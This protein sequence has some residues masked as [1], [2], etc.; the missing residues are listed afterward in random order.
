VERASARHAGNRA[1]IHRGGRILALLTLAALTAAAQDER[2]VS[3]P[4][5]QL[6]FRIWTWQSDQGGL[7]RIAY[8]IL[9]RGKPVVDTSFMGLLIQNQE[10]ILGENAGLTASHT[11]TGPGY[12][13]LT[14]E[15]M[16]NGSLGRRINLEARAYDD[17]VEF[18]YLIPR[19]TMLDEIRIEDEATEFV[20]AAPAQVSEKPLP[21]FPRMTVVDGAAHL[22]RDSSGV[23]F[24]GRTPLVCPWRQ[25]TPLSVG[26]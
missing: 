19:S 5:G 10:P 13:A 15:Y 12:R 24:V 4:D 14:V 16:Q 18:R 21:G 22:A 11:S 2:R 1:G 3:S 17:R 7:S 6:E 25:V 8:Q 9:R 26:K 20:L 23:A